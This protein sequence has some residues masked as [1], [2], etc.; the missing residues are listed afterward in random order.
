LSQHLFNAQMAVYR[1]NY[2]TI[3]P[4]DNTYTPP[5][6]PAHISTELDPI[7]G[8]PSDKQL[9]T[10]QHAVRVAESLVTSPLFDPDLNMQLSQHSFNLHFAR[11]IHDSTHG[12]YASKTKKP[13][14][15]HVPQTPETHLSTP[16]DHHSDASNPNE[17]AQCGFDEVGQS[18][19]CAAES[20]KVE[21]PTASE[22]THQIID[23][24]TTLNES[25]GVL[26]NM[27]RVLI[28]IQRNQVVVGEWTNHNF[29]HINP[30]NERGVTAAECGLPQLRF[31][32][33]K[34]KYWNH[35]EPPVLARYLKFFGIGGDLLKEGESPQLKDGQEQQARD[36]ILKHIGWYIWT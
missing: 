21:Y 15:Q 4:T 13:V 2:S 6:L 12:Q 7:V 25:K 22:I 23:M 32:Y 10:V 5:S 3:L 17:P 8:A 20:A 29:A 36:V 28:A 30:V 18:Q 34:G 26:E 9:K 24:K 19:S 33:H 1:S 16:Y 31:T 11:Y 14:S 35:L 27:N